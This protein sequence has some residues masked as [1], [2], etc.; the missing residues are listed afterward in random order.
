MKYLK[1][2]FLLTILIFIIIPIF[3]FGGLLEL[4]GKLGEKITDFCSYSVKELNHFVYNIKR[5]S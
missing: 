5:N 4:V 2:A 1:R 3:L